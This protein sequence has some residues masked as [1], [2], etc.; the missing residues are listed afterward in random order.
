MIFAADSFCNTNEQHAKPCSCFH[1]NQALNPIFCQLLLVL[2]ILQ[3]YLED[4]SGVN[5]RSE[6]GSKKGTI[7]ATYPQL[8]C[9]VDFFNTPKLR[10]CR[11]HGCI[12]KIGSDLVLEIKEKNNHKQEESWAIVHEPLP[13]D[14]SH[15]DR[16]L[17]QK[18]TNHFA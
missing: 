5:N 4:N 7:F 10:V 8:S 6:M 13:Q 11:E 17:C 12:L 15:R 3:R 9:L 14:R 2:P 1:T 18:Q 16:Q